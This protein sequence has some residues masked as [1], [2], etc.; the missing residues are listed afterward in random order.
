M[1]AVA[2]IVAKVDR[3]VSSKIAAASCARQRPARVEAE[4]RITLTERTER[5]PLW[6][7]RREVP[8]RVRHDTENESASSDHGGS[9]CGCGSRGDSDSDYESEKDGTKGL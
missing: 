7:Q 2:G 4:T 1:I 8:L 5:N 6:K 9:S 3:A